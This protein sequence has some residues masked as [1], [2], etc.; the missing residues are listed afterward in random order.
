[1]M[2]HNMYEIE[3][4]IQLEQLARDERVRHE[5]H[6]LA[7]RGQAWPP[8]VRLAFIASLLTLFRVS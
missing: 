3:R 8:F 1:M 4:I 5:Q 6:S 2:I 7:A